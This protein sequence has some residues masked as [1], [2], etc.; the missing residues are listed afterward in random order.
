MEDA[1]SC[2]W[3]YVYPKDIASDLSSFEV[4]ERRAKP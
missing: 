4:M 2:S 3:A 1:E